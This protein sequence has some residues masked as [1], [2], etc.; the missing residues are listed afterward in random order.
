ML[1]VIRFKIPRAK[2]KEKTSSYSIQKQHTC[3]LLCIHMKYSCRHT[4]NIDESRRERSFEGIIFFSES[5][6][7]QRK[8]V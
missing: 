2:L 6:K 3:N 8:N 7:M 4:R 1:Y 5:Q